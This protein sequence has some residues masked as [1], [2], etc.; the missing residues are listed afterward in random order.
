MTC[1]RWPVHGL[2]SPLSEAY[3]AH[4]RVLG[5]DFPGTL[6]CAKS[7]TVSLRRAGDLDIA[8]RLTRATRDRYRKQYDG[9][10]TPD[11]PA[12]DLNWATDL[13]AANEREEARQIALATLAEYVRVPGGRSSVHPGP[14][15]TTSVPTTWPAGTPGKEAVFQRVTHRMADVLGDQH[16][17]ALLCQANYTT[18]SRN[19]AGTGR[20]GPG[21]ADPGRTPAGTGLA[22]SGGAAEP[23]VGRGQRH[24]PPRRPGTPRLP[25]SVATDGLREVDSRT[26]VGAGVLVHRIRP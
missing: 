4:K 11:T 15:S 20:R 7:L 26:G 10:H 17:H 21:G 13:Y 5:K 24:L 12:C 14:R 9:A 23:S 25:R 18:S 8:K 6:S 19:K 22:P 2:G 3:E 16:P 1:A